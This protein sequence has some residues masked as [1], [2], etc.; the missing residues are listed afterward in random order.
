MARKLSQPTPRPNFAWWARTH[1]LTS[2]AFMDAAHSSETEHR[3]LVEVEFMEEIL[4][5]INRN[6]AAKKAN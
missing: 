2:A 1:K 5:R 3:L 6:E 4:G